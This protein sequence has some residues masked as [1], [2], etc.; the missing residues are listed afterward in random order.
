MIVSRIDHCPCPLC[1]FAFALALT[2]LFGP[3]NFDTTYVLVVAYSS[4]VSISAIAEHVSMLML[5]GEVLGK[6]DSMELTFGA[7]RELG[8]TY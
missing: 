3:L 8:A 7:R 4:S 6:T 5:M 1:P 2:L